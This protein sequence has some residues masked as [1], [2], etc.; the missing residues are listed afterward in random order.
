[1]NHNFARIK[2]QVGQ[3]ITKSVVHKSEIR[4][5]ETLYFRNIDDSKLQVGFKCGLTVCGLAQWRIFSTKV[6]LKNCIW[7]YHKTDRR[8]AEP[9]ITPNRCCVQL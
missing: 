6:Q 2:N 9:A 8:S 7:T 3:G 4:K 1:L 5:N